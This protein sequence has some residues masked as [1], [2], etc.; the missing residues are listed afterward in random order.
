MLD[1]FDSGSN[2]VYE[3]YG[4]FFHGHPRCISN[5]S[6]VN[7]VSKKSYKKLFER[8]LQRELS[9]KQ[10]GYNVISKW[11]CEWEMERQNDEVK[12][13]LQTCDISSP[14]NPKDAFFGG[15]VETFKM[16][17]CDEGKKNYVDVCSLYPFVVS[18]KMFP[19]GHPVVLSRNLSTNISNYF[20]FIKCKILPPKKLIIPVLPVRVGQKLLFPL[21]NV[22]AKN[23][24]RSIL[25]S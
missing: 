20:G 13:V 10:K 3:F 24:V 6:S 19:V 21:C 5:M 9:L 22:C 18:R 14:I 2:T 1:G 17:D 12:D 15:R 16:L 4:C 23:Q 11:E 25:R 7:P 8:T